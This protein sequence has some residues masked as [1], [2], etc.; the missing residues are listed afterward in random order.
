MKASARYAKIVTW[1]EEDQVYIGLAPGLL[2]G[3]CHGS[4]EKQVFQELCEI[5]EEVIETIES[6]GMPLPPPSFG[7][8]LAVEFG[9]LAK[10]T[11]A[12]PPRQDKKS[13]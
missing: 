12:Q 4:D 5:V 9:T 8:E 13:A 10:S 2:D 6:E 11:S 1:S 3:C 7:Y